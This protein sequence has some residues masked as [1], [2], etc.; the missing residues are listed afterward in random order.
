MISV[1][2]SHSSSAFLSILTIVLAA[3]AAG[4]N[5]PDKD[6]A[7]VRYASP[8][9]LADAKSRPRRPPANPSSGA[10]QRMRADQN[11]VEQF[12]TENR[13]GLGIGN[14][15]EVASAEGAGD[16]NSISDGPSG[17]IQSERGSDGGSG[18]IGSGYEI[19][20]SSTGGVFEEGLSV[21]VDGAGSALAGPAINDA[22]SPAIQPR[23]GLEL[24]STSPGDG[25]SG[26]TR[27]KDAA[28][29]QPSEKAG[30]G[31]SRGDQGR[32]GP[33]ANRTPGQ[34]TGGSR[35]DLNSPERS[36]FPRTTP[37]TKSEDGPEELV[38]RV[39][40]EFTSPTTQ[41]AERMAGASKQ[42]E[43][44][45]ARDLSVL[46][47]PVGKRQLIRKYFSNLRGASTSRPTSEQ[48]AARSQPAQ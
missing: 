26:A 48:M 27:N 34:L 24:G 18:T 7:S 4:C 47:L 42:Y 16:N 5:E 29:E 2:R 46:K 43:H 25:K 20:G 35:R 6:L 1:Q 44:N 30:S 39:S 23:T 21:N 8:E 17:H 13:S 37:G 11:S 31:S 19:K 32:G 3:S 41:Q 38:E 9:R 22:N 45:A 14:V 36:L 10:D 33:Q 12:T 28:P 40:R 15:G